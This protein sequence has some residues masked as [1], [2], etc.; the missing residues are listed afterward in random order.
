MRQL[1]RLV[2]VLSIAVPL[3]AFELPGIFSDHMVLQRDMPVPVWGKAEPGQTVVVALNGEERGKAQADEH[4]VWRVDLPAMPA[5]DTPKTLEVSVS[6][7]DSSAVKRFSDVLV[8]DVWHCGGQSNMSWAVRGSM[9]PEQELA[10]ANNP[11][12]RLF[13][14]LHTSVSEPKFDTGGAWQVATPETVMHWSAVGYYFGRQLQAS[15]G[16]PIGLFVT[17]WGGAAAESY[18]SN[19]TLASDPVTN[20]YLDWYQKER[21]EFLKREPNSVD[22]ATL[23]E[24]HT[25]PGPTEASTDY[26]LPGFD[27]QGWAVVEIPV[28]IEKT[29]LGDI[30]GGV[31]F[32]KTLSLPAEFM[33]QS[34]R[35]NLG[36]IDDFD[37]TYVNGQEVG[38]TGQETPSYYAHPRQYDVPATLTGDDSITIAVRMFDNFG[39]GG[40]SSEASRLVLH[41]LGQPEAAVSLAGE[42]RMLGDQ[43][44]SP[45][46]LRSGA[47]QDVAPQHIPE[48]LWNGMIHPVAPYAHRGVI[49]YQGEA[50]ANPW[51][52]VAY[53]KLLPMMIEDWRTLW[54]QPGDAR[55]T[56]FLIVQL[57]NFLQHAESPPDVDY[58]AELRDAQTATANTVPNAHVATAID[59]GEAGDIHPKNKQDVG[60]RLARL[61][62][63]HVYGDTSVVPVGPTLSEVEQ[64][65]ET[66]VVIHFTHAQGLATK[67]GKAPRGFAIRP[68]GEG[69]WHWAEAEVVGSTVH[70]TDPELRQGPFE[71]RYAYSINPADGPNGVNLINGEGLPAMPF[72]TDP[73]P[74]FN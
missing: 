40:F 47:V 11:N 33:G 52:A 17:S 31:W 60:L 67:D 73:V 74:P 18:T 72:R 46:D 25:D 9:N 39:E 13:R 8:G 30:D 56:P 2:M 66:G 15:Q 45:G 62:E 61:A 44:L 59:V 38:R 21:E 24:V 4:G 65:P 14:A 35:L 50:N 49:W 16:V 53:R 5:S 58:W 37:V 12:I 27:D 28:M 10:T 23:P 42:W 63:H 36:A 69:V 41:P 32:R 48:A 20:S 57:A 68:Q 55:D 34:L 26:V 64:H 1:F 71:V 51:R 7:G 43:P 70:L 22:P 6:G 54:G 19:P 3:H 29:E